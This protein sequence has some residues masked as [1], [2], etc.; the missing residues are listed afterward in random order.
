MVKRSKPHE[1]GRFSARA[2][3]TALVF[4]ALL[5]LGSV[6]ALAQ[7]NLSISISTDRDVFQA[8]EPV[9]VTYT[10]NN[11]TG[12]A[13][14]LEGTSCFPL[15]NLIVYNAD[16]LEIWN[17]AKCISCCCTCC[18]CPIRFVTRDIPTG[19]STYRNDIT[20]YQFQTVDFGPCGC[21]NQ[22]VDAGVYYLVGQFSDEVVSDPIAIEIQAQ[23]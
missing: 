11:Q 6:A 19:E 14:H 3:H 12:Q 16:G 10:V 17:A 15:F 23:K 2:R 22:I 20:W 13:I 1:S 8:R 9:P 18:E 4:S 21:I 7:D 5:V